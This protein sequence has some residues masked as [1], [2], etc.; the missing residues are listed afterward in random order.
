MTNYY[1]QNNIH[2]LEIPVSEFSIVMVDKD[3]RKCGTNYTNAGYFGGWHNDEGSYFTLPVAHV[4]CDFEA[5]SAA[6]KFHATERGKFSGKKYTFDSSKFSY[7]NEFYKKSVSTLV[8]RNGKASIEDF[9]SVPSGLDYAVSGVPIMRNGE[10]VKFATYVRGQGWS[11][12]SLSADISTYAGVK[13]DGKVIYIMGLKTTT[14][15]SVLTAEAFKKFKALGMWDVIKLDGGGSTYFNVNGKVV[16]N[17]GGNRRINTIIRFGSV[18]NG[19][20]NTSTS[21]QTAPAPSTNI[22]TTPSTSTNTQTNPYKAPTIALRLYSTNKEGVRW[23]QWELNYH[24]FKCDIDGSFGP[25]TYNKLKEFQKSRG[26]E[27]D[28]ICGPA[29]KKALLIH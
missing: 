20:P 22:Q 7:M 6:C 9:V 16:F 2:I 28:G 14:Y 4:V 26:L 18:V 21:T 17:L 3:K 25:D 19:K 23:L 29:T 13:K 5:T 11:G 12:G 24:G 8:V 1:I 15:N 10:D 27:R